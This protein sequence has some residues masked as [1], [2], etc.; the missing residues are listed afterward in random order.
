[1]TADRASSQPGGL[2]FAEPAGRWVLA[3]T[4]LGSSIAFLDATVVNI[5]LPAI[6]RDLGAGVTGLTWTVNAYTLTLAA[7]VLVGG[8][9]GD[10]LGRRRVFMVGVTWF[11]LASLACA[12]AIDIGMLIGFRALQGVGAAL[13]TPGALAILQSSFR[14]EDRSRAIGAWSGLAGITG[15]VGPLLGGW[16]VDVASWR[17]IFFINVP[18]VLVVLAISARHVPES[19]DESAVGR[20]DLVG[21]LLV[22]LGLGSLTYGLAAWSE[23]GLESVAVQV[24]IV[25]GVVAVVGFVAWEA[26]TSHPMLPLSI[27]SAP[28]FAVTNVV[29][30]VVYAAL[31]GVFFWLVVTLQVVAGWSALTAGFAL[32]PVTVLMLLFS[33]RAGVIGDRLGPRIPMTV[34]PLVAALGVGLLTRIGSEASFASD[35]LLPVTLLGAGLTL[36]VT[37]LTAT[38]LGAVDE[39]R[40]GLASGVNNAVARTGGL[41]LVAALPAIT[42]LSAGFDDP[43]ALEPAFRT[44]MLVCAV[45]LGVGGA[46]AALG[47]R[48]VAPEQPRTEG[49]SCPRRHCAVGTTPIGVTDRTDP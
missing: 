8:S 44:A 14:A 7:F 13:L 46:I 9:L 5:A 21:S 40:A 24:S 15:A 1:M 31:G 4:V 38:V 17:W 30:F 23:Q 3:A 20:L 42:G 29:T 43:A 16:L 19:K 34:G 22:A 48:P 41:L 32:L 6:G 33:P 39:S 45:L 26:L 35:V 37:P 47:L 18:V 49:P 27:F 36:T 12:L 25:L 11:G 28:R 2:R 10:R